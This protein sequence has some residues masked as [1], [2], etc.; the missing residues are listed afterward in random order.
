M[1]RVKMREVGIELINLWEIPILGLSHWAVE[2]SNR[3]GPKL[4]GGAR[5]QTLKGCECGRGGY[6]WVKTHN[7]NTIN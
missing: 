7:D 2:G 4:G 3:L 5:D 6:I 1:G